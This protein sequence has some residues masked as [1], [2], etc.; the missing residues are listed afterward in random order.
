MA[1]YIRTPPGI[2]VAVRGLDAGPRAGRGEE[3][4]D[5]IDTGSLAGLRAR[6]LLSVMLYSFARVSAVL[7][8]SR[9]DYYRQGSRGWLHEKGGKRHDVPAHHRAPEALDSSVA[10]GGLEG[11]R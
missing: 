3:L 5:C 7:G 11:G 10:A 4:L 6:A 9:Q 2:A 1:A 8:M